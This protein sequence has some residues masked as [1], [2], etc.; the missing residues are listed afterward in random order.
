M[1]TAAPISLAPICPIQIPCK[2]VL[3]YDFQDDPFPVCSNFLPP[4]PLPTRVVEKRARKPDFA[5][6]CSSPRKRQTLGSKGKKRSSSVKNIDRHVRFR[7]DSKQF[8]GLKPVS[9]ALELT[10]WKFYTVQSIHSADDILS[11]FKSCSRYRAVFKQVGDAINHLADELLE[12]TGVD[13]T[14]PVL[15]RGGGRG[16]LL[17]S[18]HIPT[19]KQLRDM[20]ALALKRA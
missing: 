15:P 2:L 17:G 19:F 5:E 20:F 3:D 1:A 12:N 18:A 11:L 16:L 10:I 13:A 8:D 7:E 6:V 4:T 14:L 9:E